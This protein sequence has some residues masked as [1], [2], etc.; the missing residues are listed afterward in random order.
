[1]C[2]VDVGLLGQ[3]WWNRDKPQAFP[4]FN[5]KHRCRDF[6]VVRK[7]AEEHQALHPPPDGYLRPPKA[8]DVL[9]EIP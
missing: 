7:W 9:E 5:T 4:D 1:M 2:T 8:E 6:G 3:V